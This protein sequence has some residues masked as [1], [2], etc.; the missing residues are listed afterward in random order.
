MCFLALFKQKTTSKKG[1]K[2]N[3][4]T[5]TNINKGRLINILLQKLFIIKV[6]KFELFYYTYRYKGDENEIFFE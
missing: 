5:K 4:H 6:D 2:H 3:K 1:K